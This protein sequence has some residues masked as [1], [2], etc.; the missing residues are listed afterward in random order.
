[1]RLSAVRGFHPDRNL[2]LLSTVATASRPPWLA[3]ELRS[4]FA[5]HEGEI[6]ASGTK[7][8]REA[9]TFHG[10]DATP[11]VL[12]ESLAQTLAGFAQKDSESSMFHT[13]CP[14]SAIAGSV[15]TMKSCGQRTNSPSSRCQLMPASPVR[16]QPSASARQDAGQ[17]RSAGR[18]S[19]ANPTWSGN[20][21]DGES[22]T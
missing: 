15:Q 13:E 18:A 17:S 1:M 8:H 4:T 21:H 22:A 6:N 11:D 5:E 14:I 12:S 9:R 19:V 2:A 20:F 7:F 10:T 3:D 16:Q